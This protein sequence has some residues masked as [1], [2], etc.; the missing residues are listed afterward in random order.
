MLPA[1]F[2]LGARWHR[3]PS[4]SSSTYLGWL[5]LISP[6]PMT[7]ILHFLTLPQL[8]VFGWSASFGLSYFT[9]SCPGHCS[10]AVVVVLPSYVS[11]CCPSL[12]LHFLARC[13][14]TSSFHKLFSSDMV[15]P[16]NTEDSSQASV[17]EKVHCSV[18][19]LVHFS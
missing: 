17:L 14:H 15:L 6:W 13:L 1:T 19:S 12:P 11:N 5:P 16:L 4:Q 9:L 8:S 7:S 10:I 3:R 2:P 18:V